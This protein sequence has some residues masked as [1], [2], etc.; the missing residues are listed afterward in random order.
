M[1]TSSALET[2]AADG[3]RRFRD[4]VAARFACASA[5]AV[6]AE[7]GRHHAVAVMRRRAAEFAARL[8][9]TNWLLD[10]GVGWGWHWA[11]HRTGPTVVGV[12]LSLRNLQIARRLLGDARVVL[13]CADA[14]ALPLR[15]GMMAGVWSVQTVQHLA[16]AEF[17]RCQ[18]ELDRVLGV[19][20][21]LE[22][23]TVHPAPLK[24]VLYRLVGRRLAEPSTTHDGRNLARL[25]AD[26]WA[27][28][29]SAFR[30][31]HTTLAVGYSELFFHPDLGL[32]PRPYPMR[33]ETWL[34]DRAPSVAGLIAGQSYVLITS[35][36]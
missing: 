9:Q 13:V 3:E 29:W 36:A 33:L 15:T 26:A 21:V 35:R 11:D 30:P 12:D 31:G 4:T 19:D 8:G 28:A 17:D 24:R 7:V 27:R 16:R 20:A 2:A 34:A 5:A 32:R 18:A 14:A 22:V 6:M 25:P 10:L 23:H 1:T